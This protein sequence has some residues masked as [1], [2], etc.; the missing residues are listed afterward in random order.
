MY[1]WSLCLLMMCI[2]GCL[3]ALVL[4]AFVCATVERSIRPSVG[5]RLVVDYFVYLICAVPEKY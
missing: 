2:N 1:L 3:C 5:F 4:L